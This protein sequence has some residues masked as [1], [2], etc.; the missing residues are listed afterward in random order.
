M[1]S[2]KF[3]LAVLAAGV[4]L[5]I[6][7]ILLHG[8]I[9]Q[10]AYYSVM[11]DVFNPPGSPVLFVLADFIIALVYAWVYDKVYTSFGGGAKG[12]ATFGFYAGVITSFPTWLL[13]HHIFRGFPMDLAWIWTANGIVWSVV[14]GAII[15]AIY[16]KGVA[17]RAA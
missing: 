14:L 5:N 4:V 7:D 15:G 11:S 9:L 10:G 2:G 6:L 13:M 12:G 16:K 3:W 17:A 1:T 8:M